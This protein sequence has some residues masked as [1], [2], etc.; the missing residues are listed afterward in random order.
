[1]SIA[2]AIEVFSDGTPVFAK[3]AGHLGKVASPFVRNT[4]T[5]GGNIIMAQRLQFASDIAT[6][7]MAAGS[8]VTIQTAS[9]MLCLTLEQFLEQPPCDAKT[10]LLSI[11]VPD[12]GSK[13]CNL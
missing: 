2:K 13:K 6:V 4:A 3:I 7:L 1:V 12:W 11:F 9:K 5:V 10:I 8:T